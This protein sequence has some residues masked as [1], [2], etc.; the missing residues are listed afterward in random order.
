MRFSLKKALTHCASVFLLGLGL[1]NVTSCS[2]NHED[3]TYRLII[4]GMTDTEERRQSVDFTIPY[5]TSE[6]VLVTRKSDDI[7][8]TH[9]YT[10]EELQ[11]IL[12]GE[13]LVSQLGTV[14]N[15]MLSIFEE[16]FGTTTLNG[17]DTFGTAATMVETG[18]AF[19]FTAELPVAQSY[20]SNPEL[21]IM[22][23]DNSILGDELNNLSVSIGVGKGNEE[24][25]EKVNGVLEG[26]SQDTQNGIMTQMVNFSTNKNEP[27][28]NIGQ[29]IVGTNGT[30]YVGLECNY[31][32]FNWT[33]T[34]ENN[35]TYPIE[36]KSTEFAEGYDIEIAKIIATELGMTLKVQ[37]MEWDA[38]LPWAALT[39]EGSSTGFF[40]LI[41]NYGTQFGYGILTTLFLAIIGTLGGL[42]IGLFLG[43]GRTIKINPYDNTFVK[44][45]KKAV[46]FICYLYILIFRGTPMMIQGM[47][48][49]LGLPMLIPMDWVNMGTNVIFNGYFYCGAIVIV[50]NTAA[51]IGEIIRGGINS[52]DV[53][54][55]EAGRSLGLNYF[56]TMVRII[57]PQAIKNSIPAIGNEFIVNIK[58]SSVL[59]VIGLTELYGWGKIVI[60]TTY[61]AIGV[62]FI[63]AIIYLILTL[64]FSLIL[65]LVEKKLN[66]EVVFN[67]N[68]FR[69]F[70]LKKGTN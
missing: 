23:I 5:Y 42:V 64:V 67:L 63:V 1:T 14:T 55:Y 53:G 26:I 70:K 6:L 21:Q 17:V 44:G 8:S 39:G 65:K 9:T 10:E 24:F 2:S 38:L 54:Q 27:T 15:D 13:N 41:G 47:I 4:A 50:L 46:N 29:P 49:F 51:Y 22:H 68:Y 16:K 28:N 48:F 20:A 62:Y 52:I 66:G 40:E 58:D 33:N 11:T 32:S 37:K 30:L 35:Y 59:N 36:G 43:I 34:T 25:I 18:G 7:N 31:P 57:L 56:Q 12:P 45:V 61:N 19:A 60:N 69:H 3:N